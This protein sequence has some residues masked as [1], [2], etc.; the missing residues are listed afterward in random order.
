M[1]VFDV[2]DNR[3][4][5]LRQEWKYLVDERCQLCER[6][7]ELKDPA[8]RSEITERIEEVE[9]VASTL[10]ERERVLGSRMVLECQ[11]GVETSFSNTYP[12]ENHFY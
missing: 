10:L 12:K 1:I 5:T 11:K 7:L 4:S 2:A 9:G 8:Q 3:L 6:R